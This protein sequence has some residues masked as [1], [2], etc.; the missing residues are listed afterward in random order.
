MPIEKS[1]VRDGCNIHFTSFGSGPPVLFIQGVGV[2][3]DAWKPQT[4][5]L[6]AH[7]Q[8][9]SFDNRG[10]GRSQPPSTNLTVEQLA[11][12]ALAVIDAIG[13]SSTHIVGHS[14]GGAVAQCV[15]IKAPQR[16]RSLSLL[17]TFARGSDAG[18]NGRMMWLGARSRIGTPRMRR[19][20]FLEM[21]APPSALIGVDRE[22]MARDM[23]PVF[24]HDLADHAPIENQQLSA[25]RKFD[26]TPQLAGFASIPTLVVSAEF[27]PISTPAIGRKMA[28]G[29]PGSRYVLMPNTAHGVPLLSASAINALLYEHFAG[30]EASTAVGATWAGKSSLEVDD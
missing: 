29:I 20:A 13:W 15:A 19:S 2:H 8:C 26:A 6:S 22:A 1:V 9:V 25:L 7:Y 21:L 3:G 17:C 5:V 30:A 23:K 10:I 18:A 16:V 24:G 11:D 4:D 27:D 12:D 28:D 14:L